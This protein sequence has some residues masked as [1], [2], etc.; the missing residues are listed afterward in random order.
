M[1]HSILL[2]KILLKLTLRRVSK[3]HMSQLLITNLI[4]QHQLH[5]RQNPSARLPESRH[6][7]RLQALLLQSDEPNS[8][9]PYTS[10]QHHLHRR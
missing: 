8:S 7:R 1:T 3:T 4:Q 10:H 9:A 2:G 6:D 5:P